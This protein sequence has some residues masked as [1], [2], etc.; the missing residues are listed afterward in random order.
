MPTYKLPQVTQVARQVWTNTAK[1]L[2]KAGTIIFCLSVILW[3]M[4]YYPRL[5][6]MADGSRRDEALVQQLQQ[7][8]RGV[9]E[10][11][12]DTATYPDPDSA[13]HAQQALAA[14]SEPGLSQQQQIKLLSANLNPELLPV[15]VEAAEK[16]V[17]SEQLRHSIAGRMGHVLEPLIRPLGYDWKIGVGLVGS[18]AAREVFVS[19]M[20]IVYNAGSEDETADLETAMRDDTGPSGKPVW[21]PLVAVSLLI[22]FVLAMQCM[23]TLA[24]VRRETGGWRWPIAMLLYMNGLAYVV[25][26][27]V[28]QV[29]KVLIA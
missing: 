9:V 1:F 28:Y 4:T 14:A 21:T 18:F 15:L 12:G 23:S 7:V 3:A 27:I 6:G 2:T 11:R 26:L 22:W 5:P 20:A 13:A 19:T 16:T 8:N 10:L 25:C 29:G 24:I 17:A